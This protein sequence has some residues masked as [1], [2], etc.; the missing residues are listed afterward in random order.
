MIFHDRL[1]QFPQL[2][3]LLMVD[4][5]LPEHWL[6]EPRTD[7][8]SDRAWRTFT[9]SLMWSNSQGTDGRLPATS[10]RFLYPHGVD[11]A[12]AAELITAGKWE[13]LSDGG[14]RV[15]HWAKSQSLAAD[16]ERQRERN[17]AN[18]QAK[19]DRERQ[20]RGASSASASNADLPDDVPDDD[21]GYAGGQARQGKDSVREGELSVNSALEI[22]TATRCQE[23]QRLAAFNKPPCPEHRATPPAVHP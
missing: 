5:R 12:T 7:L 18:Q 4:A 3:W 20:A 13:R 19:R 8:L 6:Y 15:L 17:R 23:C 22:P 2:G 16:V 14:Y 21:S 1:A 9:G 10:L 11:E